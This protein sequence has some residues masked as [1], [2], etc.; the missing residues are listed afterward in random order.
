VLVTYARL[1]GL[2]HVSETGLLGGLGRTLVYANFPVAIAALGVLAVLLERGAPRLPAVAAL[3][4]CA[5]T[6]LTVDQ[7]DL[8]AR[9]INLLPAAG[10]AIALAL[11]LLARPRLELASRLPLDPARV[12]LGAVLLVLSVPWLFAEIGFYAPDPILADEPSP[13]EPIA[14]VHLG[15][16]HGFDGV[17]L[18]LAALLLSR[19][20]RSRPAQATIALM[21]A[22][23]VGNAVQDG[24]LEQIV[25]RG[26]TDVRIP[27]LLYPAF[28][29]GW[30][31][32]VAAAAGVYA[33]IRAREG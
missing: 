1:D 23:G 19:V 2:Y 7:D 10:V 20:A 15:H 30:A 28:S 14:A 27:S 8:D 5:L 3:A 21:L 12:A 16:H 9:A 11:T 22:Y 33:L 4:L 32:L 25:K 29:P 31:V 17:L 24:W 6:P 18:G 13:D 26:T